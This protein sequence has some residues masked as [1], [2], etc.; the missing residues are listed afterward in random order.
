MGFI[1]PHFCSTFVGRPKKLHLFMMQRFPA[2]TNE[3]RLRQNLRRDDQH[4][5][6]FVNGDSLLKLYYYNNY[7]KHYYVVLRCPDR[8]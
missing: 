7:G 4:F 1:I 3:D 5:T 2:K 8:Y 6:H